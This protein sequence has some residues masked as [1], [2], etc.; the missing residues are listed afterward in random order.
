MSGDEDPSDELL[1]A[2]R[3][4][5][6][7]RRSDRYND[8]QFRAMREDA[9]GLGPHKSVSMCNMRRAFSPQPSQPQQQPGQSSGSYSPSHQSAAVAAAHAAL[10]QSASQRSQQQA[11]SA[12][13]SPP[14]NGAPGRSP[15]PA[16]AMSF[17]GAGSAEA[18]P[19]SGPLPAPAAGVRSF[20]E[21]QSHSDIKRSWTPERAC[22]L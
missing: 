2:I 3:Q 12:P 6:S 10:G 16:A 14:Q 18:A 8:R 13:S 5:Q 19:S 1:H 21:S 9:Q 7:Q 20:V 11:Q 4:Q 15:P 22:S 17:S